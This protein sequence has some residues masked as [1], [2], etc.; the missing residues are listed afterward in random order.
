[1]ARRPNFYPLGDH[2]AVIRFGEDMDPDAHLAVKAFTSLLDKSAPGGVVD[3]ISALTTVTVLY[4]PVERSY[5]EVVEE[6]QGL[7]SSAHADPDVEVRKV[8]I[9]VCYGGDLGPDLDL[10]AS[11][12]GL[13]AERVTEIHCA[14]QYVVQMIGFV[15]GFPYLSGLD[16]RIATPRRDSPREKIPAGSVGIAGKQT[17]IYPSETPG[18]WRLIGRTPLRLFSPQRERPSLLQAGDR[19]LFLPIARDEFDRMARDEEP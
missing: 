4:D 19:V 5:A 7:A 10:V 15:P 11:H 16:E 14:A 6:L 2:A 9:P 8:E 18:G 17:G 1:M 3:Y 13:T 12:S